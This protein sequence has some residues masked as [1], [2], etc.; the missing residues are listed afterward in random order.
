[1]CYEGTLSNGAAYHRATVLSR[2]HTYQTQRGLF[3]LT[4]FNLEDPGTIAVQL[5][6]RNSSQLDVGYIFTMEEVDQ[7]RRLYD[8]DKWTLTRIKKEIYKDAHIR[9][10]ACAIAHGRWDIEGKPYDQRPRFSFD[11]GF[12]EL[13][14]FRV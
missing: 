8:E 11:A 13:T 1:M 2:S 12:I 5:R 3:A 6:P 10:I 9:E 4:L 14:E 7:I